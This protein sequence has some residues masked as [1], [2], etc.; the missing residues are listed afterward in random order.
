MKGNIFT[1][2]NQLKFTN[3]AVVRYKKS[4]LRYIEKD[5]K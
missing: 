1:P 4:G 5:L 2:V 3:V